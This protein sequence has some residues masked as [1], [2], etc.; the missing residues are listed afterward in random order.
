VPVGGSSLPVNMAGAEQAA[1]QKAVGQLQ[2]RALNQVAAGRSEEQGREDASDLVRATQE[3]DGATIQGESRGA[4][5]FTLKK[6][7]EKEKKEPAPGERPD[8]PDG[9]G[10]HLDVRG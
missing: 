3:V 1:L 8:D 5:S 2:E 9:R 10:R 4:H 7:E 6:E